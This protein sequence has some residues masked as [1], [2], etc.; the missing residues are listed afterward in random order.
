VATKPPCGAV[1]KSYGTERQGKDITMI[2]SGKSI[3]DE[4]K[5]T[6]DEA[7]KGLNVVKTYLFTNQKGQA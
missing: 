7:S 5:Q 3:K 4:R 2:I 6:I 1:I